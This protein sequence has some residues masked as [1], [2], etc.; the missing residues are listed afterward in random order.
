M[1]SPETSLGMHRGGA[2]RPPTPTY[3]FRWGLC[4][5]WDSLQH[6]SSP[7]LSPEL[8]YPLSRLV[9]KEAAQGHMHS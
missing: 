2:S 6:A 9:F 3:P 4:L 8:S 7:K 1:L 5:Q